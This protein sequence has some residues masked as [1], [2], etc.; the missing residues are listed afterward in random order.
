M[1]RVHEPQ[2]IQAMQP[3]KATQNVLPLQPKNSPVAGINSH[4]Y[5]PTSYYI[6]CNPYFPFQTPPSSSMTMYGSCSQHERLLRPSFNAEEIQLAISERLT[7][8]AGVDPCNAIPSQDSLSST[9][10]QMRSIA[11]SALLELATTPKNYAI[12]NESNV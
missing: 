3:T 7:Q 12:R 10:S 5:V 6:D 4:P 9:E 2:C 8:C 1:Q 11:A